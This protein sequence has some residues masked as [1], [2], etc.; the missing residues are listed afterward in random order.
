MKAYDLVAGLSGL[1]MSRFANAAESL[2]MFPTMV[3]RG[4]PESGGVVYKPKSSLI[5]SSV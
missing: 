5:I 1:T 3:R 4:F 2:A